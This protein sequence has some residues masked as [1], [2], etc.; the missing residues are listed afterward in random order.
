[1]GCLQVSSFRACGRYNTKLIQESLVS[2][3][4][5]PQERRTE[6]RYKCHVNVY[7]QD[8]DVLLG[9]ALNLNTGG[10]LLVTEKPLN[11]VKKYDLSFGG[12]KDEHIMQRI[13]VSAYPVWQQSENNISRYYTG[14]R[15][16]NLDANTVAKIET[17][18]YELK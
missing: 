15:F 10:M 8:E 14:M 3:Q 11:P 7:P 6:P 9:Y 4:A 2:T 1:M 13:M 12:D 5:E 16:S 17:I 18:L